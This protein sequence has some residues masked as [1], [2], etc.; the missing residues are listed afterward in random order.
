VNCGY[1]FFRKFSTALLTDTTG[2][3]KLSESAKSSS[4]RPAPAGIRIP[5]GVEEYNK[6][7]TSACNCAKDLS[8][9]RFFLL[10]LSS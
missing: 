1:K 3:S 5:P 2:E 9:E 7:F 4:N 8:P 6:V 10:F